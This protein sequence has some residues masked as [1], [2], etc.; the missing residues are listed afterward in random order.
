MAE[1]T[2]VWDGA[3]RFT[4]TGPTG[5]VT[6]TDAPAGPGATAATPMELILHAL[7]GCAGVDVVSTLLKMR[8]PLEG[9]EI[10]VTACRADTH[11]RVYTGIHLEF[12]VRGPVDEDRLSRAIE[13]SHT[14]YCSVAAML[15]G[16]VPITYSHSFL[17]R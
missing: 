5:L 13:L 1:Y 6:V 11:P 3:L 16:T 10:G 9:L 12:R 4:H 14:K 15:A 8:Q 17:T 2:T 7:A